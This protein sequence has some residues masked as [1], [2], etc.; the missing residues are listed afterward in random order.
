MSE[1]SFEDTAL[2]LGDIA[3][4]QPP[5]LVSHGLELAHALQRAVGARGHDGGGWEDLLAF[6]TGPG[7]DAF[8]VA[9]VQLP[10]EGCV[11]PILDRA[12]EIRALVD[13]FRHHRDR[14]VRQPLDRVLR[15]DRLRLKRVALHESFMPVVLRLGAWFTVIEVHEEHPRALRERIVDSFIERP[16]PIGRLRCR[17]VDAPLV[18]SLV[19]ID[20]AEAV[21]LHRVGLEGP[22]VGWSYSAGSPK[23]S[24][25]AAHHLV[26]DGPSFACLRSDFARRVRA[27]RLALGLDS[28]ESPGVL[29][30]PYSKADSFPFEPDSSTLQ[31]SRAAH[32]SRWSRVAR[33]SGRASA[34]KRRA[35]GL[36]HQEMAS[37]QPSGPG[38]YESSIPKELAELLRERTGVR[39]WAGPTK[40]SG[41]PV[42]PPS[43]RFATL[44][45]VSFSL[46]EFAYAYCRA[47]HDAMLRHDVHY[48]GQGF[49]FVVP[50][51]PRGDASQAPLSSRARPVLCS[52]HTRRGL[53]EPLTAFSR[54]LL[55]RL[56][57]ADR[58]QDLLSR[59]L[60]DVF[61]LPLPAVVQS[62]VVRLFERAPRDGGT[63]LGGR[64]LFAYSAVP[65]DFVDPSA[66]HSGVHGGLFSGSCHERGGVSLT[67][68]D[69]GARRDLCA[70]GTGL[71]RPQAPMDF[72]WERLASLLNDG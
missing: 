42:E 61:R 19:P 4:T 22:L 26:V 53:P 63:F 39:S 18:V 51:V 69:R 54:R 46:C 20:L 13:V 28:M 1:P 65:D 48:Q 72:F 32:A 34:S 6:R 5:R 49:T 12:V 44:H 3:P 25:L 59:V 36:A 62:S 67:V 9:P 15:R 64:G 60:H 7:A 33:R 43:I 71:F 17:R 30:E 14:H 56:D 40:L 35:R 10:E 55:R 41:R 45:R 8:L 52:L 2:S 21:H 31:S 58:G 70:V 47:Q 38:R 16:R 23:L 37:A 27:L 11:D 50:H 24:V 68:I 66:T 57:E 29:N